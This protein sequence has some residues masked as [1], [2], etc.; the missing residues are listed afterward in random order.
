[1]IKEVVC[2]MRQCAWPLF[3]WQIENFLILEAGEAARHPQSQWLYGLV[4]VV[5]SYLLP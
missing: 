2:P 3:Y 5:A 4:K 1:M